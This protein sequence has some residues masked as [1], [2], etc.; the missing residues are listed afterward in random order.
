MDQSNL[1]GEIDNSKLNG[2]MSNNGLNENMDMTYEK[3]G[4][5]IGKVGGKIIGGSAGHQVGGLP[6]AIIGEEI[7]APIGKKVGEGAGKILDYQQR[8]TTRKFKE[9][10]EFGLKMGMDDDDARDYAFDRLP[11]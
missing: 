9:D 4:G 1:N 10:W 3:A 8:E 2:N 7:C 6:G 11:M 5:Y